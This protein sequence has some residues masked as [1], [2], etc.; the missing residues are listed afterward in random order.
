VKKFFIVLGAIF[1]TLIVLGAVALVLIAI[2]GIALDKESKAYVDEAVPAIISSW[3]G[4]EL[5]D[6]ASPELK[7]TTSGAEVGRIFSA[8]RLLG[9]ML[10]Y[11]GSEGQ[12]LMAQYLTKGT[13]ISA[14]YIVRGEFERGS[15]EIDIKL[16]KHGDKWQINGFHVKPTYKTQRPN[17]ASWPTT[18]L[19][20]TFDVDLSQTI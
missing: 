13:T 7:Q 16:I 4:Q 5:L 2:R 1:L 3:S 19:R 11:R 14:S 20:R 8:C 15:A 12:G 10:A 18:P 9:K 17:Q 6:R